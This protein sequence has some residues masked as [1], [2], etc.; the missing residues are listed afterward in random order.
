MW[1]ERFWPVQERRQQALIGEAWMPDAD[2]PTINGTFRRKR[3]QAQLRFALFDRSNW[4]PGEEVPQLGDERTYY[5]RMNGLDEVLYSEEYVIPVPHFNGDL[6]EANKLA[7]EWK[8]KGGFDGAIARDPHQPYVVGRCKHE[9]IKLKPVL[10]LDLRVTER[11]ITYGE[12]TG[13]EV[14]TI[15]VAYRG[16]ATDV[17]SGMPHSR[18]ELPQIG[19]IVEVECMGLTPDGKLREPR[20]KGIR[21][22]K[23][24][25]D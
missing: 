1:V 25:A 22:D 19:A 7:A 17:G 8:A 14:Y 12:K 13:R 23:T 3:T 20:F 24:E 5:Q 11:H 21:Y 18:E 15:T 10:S 4:Q 6:D 9:V 16:V 2:F